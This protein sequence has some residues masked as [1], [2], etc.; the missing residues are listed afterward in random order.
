M[1][2]TSEQADQYKLEYAVA[3]AAKLRWQVIIYQFKKMGMIRIYIYI[4]TYIY[5]YI[6]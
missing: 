1:G 2:I 3:N 6:I 5:I 4:H